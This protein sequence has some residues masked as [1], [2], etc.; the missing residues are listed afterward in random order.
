MISMFL[1]EIRAL[2]VVSDEKALRARLEEIVLQLTGKETIHQM[3]ALAD[4]I[5][6]RGGQPKSAAEY[7][8]IFLQRLLTVVNRRLE[9]LRSGD[10]TPDSFLVPG[11]RTVLQMLLEKGITL[12]LASGTDE[13]SVKV[14]AELLGITKYFEGRIYG[15]RDDRKGFTKS[16]LVA[17]LLSAAGYRPSELIGLG[18]GFIEIYEVSRA[19]GFAV[20]LATDEPDCRSIERGKRRYLV[21]AGANIILANFENLDE[22]IPFLSFRNGLEGAARE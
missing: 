9:R 2:N 6:A 21:A 22:W 17:H 8:Q 4:E 3:S 20:G 10:A 12:Y 14:E 5:R 18:D 19:G 11:A 16:A 1:E 15:A 13:A 7:K